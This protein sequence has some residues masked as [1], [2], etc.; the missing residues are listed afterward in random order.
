MA[1]NPSLDDLA[2]QG[3]PPWWQQPP[4]PNQNGGY[5]SGGGLDAGLDDLAGQQYAGIWDKLFPREKPTREYPGP[6]LQSPEGA[7]NIPL[8]AGRGQ[9]G[10]M[11]KGAPIEQLGVVQGQ[12]RMPQGRNLADAQLHDWLG[13]QSSSRQS[14]EQYRDFLAQNRGG[15]STTRQGKIATLSA[16]DVD[17]AIKL[18]NDRISS[19]QLEQGMAPLVK[20][21]AKQRQFEREGGQVSVGGSPIEKRYGTERFK[22]PDFGP[23]AEGEIKALKGWLDATKKDRDIFQKDETLNKVYKAIQ[24]H[25]KRIDEQ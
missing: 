4:Q 8:I 19:M 11:P 3:Q 18:L 21:V 12:G 17:R 25:L 15:I 14:L 10:V 9:G 23:G 20:Q 2:Q 13:T 5:S 22:V 7:F 6:Q 16:K 24:R 1:F